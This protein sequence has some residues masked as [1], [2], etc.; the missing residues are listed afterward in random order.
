MDC[1]SGNSMP[2]GNVVATTTLTLG[3][4]TCG[5]HARLTSPSSFRKRFRPSITIRTSPLAPAFSSNPGNFQARVLG[6]QSRGS[7][8]SNLCTNSLTN[9]FSSSLTSNDWRVHPTTWTNWNSG[10]S[11]GCF[12]IALFSAALRLASQAATIVD[13]PE[14]GGPRTTNGFMTKGTPSG[15]WSS[16]AFVICATNACSCFCLAGSREAWKVAWSSL[17]KPPRPSFVAAD[18]T[19]F[20]VG[21][22]IVAALRAAAWAALS[23]GLWLAALRAHARGASAQYCCPWLRGSL[24]KASAACSR[25]SPPA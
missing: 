2:V 21:C 24:C 5:N 7:G 13:F 18:W 25:P 4:K 9:L 1:A 14:P 15:E 17:S 22:S 23:W 3:G 11:D 12:I 6:D 8:R 19:L 10:V 16:Q 20:I